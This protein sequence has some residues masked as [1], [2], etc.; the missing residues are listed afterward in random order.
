MH[1][2]KFLLTDVLKN[3]LGF[4]GFI[5]SDWRGIDKIEEGADYRI[6]ADLG[7]NAGIDM[8]LGPLD[9][10]KFQED[11]MS[12]VEAGEL[13]I[14]RIDDTMERL[15]RVKFAAGIFE[16]PLSDRSLLDLIGCKPHREIVREAVRK[17]L[18]PLKNGKALDMIDLDKKKYEIHFSRRPK[19]LKAKGIKADTCVPFR[20]LALVVK[21]IHFGIFLKHHPVPSPCV[22]NLTDEQ[23]NN[24]D[25]VEL[26]GD[27]TSLPS[28]TKSVIDTLG[29]RLVLHLPLRTLKSDGRSASSRHCMNTHGIEAPVLLEP[30]AL[31]EW[32][33]VVKREGLTRDLYKECF[34]QNKQVVSPT[35]SAAATVKIIHVPGVREVLDYEDTHLSTFSRPISRA[36]AKRTANY[37]MDCE[38]E[39]WLQR[40]NSKQRSFQ[41]RE[42][43]E[44]ETFELMIDAFEKT[45][46]WQVGKQQKHIS[47]SIRENQGDTSEDDDSMTNSLHPGDNDAAEDVPNQ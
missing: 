23:I 10:I 22:N 11:S 44:E 8:V 12:L 2:H 21:S 32:F 19:G 4:K 27:R 17:S 24:D 13:P 45:F 30:S 3:K 35:S 29:G 31:R 38:D 46:K 14:S 37:D 41:H 15:L 47:L 6:C 28:N 7:I 26:S 18:V 33:L 9:L 1:S 16:Q 20:G 42:D 36:L 5:N 25:D 39:G 40:F 43:L 34:D